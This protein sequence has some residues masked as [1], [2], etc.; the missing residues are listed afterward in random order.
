MNLQTGAELKTTHFKRRLREKEVVPDC[1]VVCALLFGA[2]NNSDQSF[3]PERFEVDHIKK[4][5]KARR[6]KCH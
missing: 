2:P 3:E 5:K 6:W 4:A 1:Y